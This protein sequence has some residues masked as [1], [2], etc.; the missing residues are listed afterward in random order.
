MARESAFALKRNFRGMNHE[1]SLKMS[2]EALL[3][4]MGEAKSKN[5]ILEQLFSSEP[6]KGHSN[7]QQI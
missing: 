6:K 5:R 2:L 4:N 3:I 1:S 7:F